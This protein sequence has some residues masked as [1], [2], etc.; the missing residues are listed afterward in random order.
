MINVPTA[1]RTRP[2]TPDPVMAPDELRGRQRSSIMVA[3]TAAVLPCLDRVPRPAR[4]PQLTQRRVQL[5]EAR[6]GLAGSGP[7]SR[8]VW[9][10]GEYLRLR[11]S[12][13][14]VLADAGTSART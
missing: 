8:L 13:G 5:I 7:M 4:R 10:A 11:Q 1:S 9:N 6:D 2:S 3:Q 12:L 14:H